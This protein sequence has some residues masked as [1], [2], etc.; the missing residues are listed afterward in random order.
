MIR[1]FS[2]TEDIDSKVIGRKFPQVT[3]PQTQV[4]VEENMKLVEE[5]K[6]QVI[7]PGGYGVKIGKS[8]KLTDT[9]SSFMVQETPIVSEKFV[10]FFKLFVV[11]RHRLVPINIFREKELVTEKKYFILQ[12][13]GNDIANV[14]FPKSTF[15]F[16]MGGAVMDRSLLR[17]ENYDDYIQ[18]YESDNYTTRAIVK[19]LVMRTSLKNQFFYL[20]QLAASHFFVTEPVRE[21]MAKENITGFEIVEVGYVED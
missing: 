8:T 18:R 11:P 12:L 20:R 15:D 2:L 9:M 13:F 3:G 21:A 4:L 5:E 19:K 10:D 17:Y 16:Y 6:F 1:L 14:N 7:P